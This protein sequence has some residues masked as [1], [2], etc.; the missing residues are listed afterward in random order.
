VRFLLDM[1]MDVRVVKW[2]RD[3]GHDA[4]HLREEG[5]QRLPNG[6]IFA[7]AISENRIVLTFDLDFGEIAALSEGKKTSVIVFRLRNTRIS[8]VID[9]LSEVLSD[10]NSRGALAKGALVIVEESRHRVR[11]LP[12]GAD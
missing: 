3:Q 10:S 12:I 11:Y 5:L 4:I 9:R 6:E 2:L 7:K 1:C 8:H